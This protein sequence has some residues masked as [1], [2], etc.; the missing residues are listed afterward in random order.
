MMNRDSIRI[1]LIAIVVAVSGF[2]LAFQFVEPSPPKSLTI[3][4]GS[5]T[6]A[7]YAYAK[8]YAS[9]L[10][11]D[12]ITLNVLE[13]GGSV[14]NIGLLSGAKADVAFI[15]GG[16]G[17]AKENPEFQALGSLYFEPLWVFVR[18]GAPIQ[19]LSDLKNRRISAGGEGS[20]TWAVAKQLLGLN[21]IATDDQKVQH[22]SSLDAARGLIS[23]DIEA[24]FFVA[25]PTAP[26]I[27][28]LL[29]ADGLRLLSFA[30]AQAYTSQLRQLSAVTL[31]HGVVSL[32]R[33]VPPADMTLLAPAATLATTD[34]LHPALV[35]LLG[36]ATI[37]VHGAGGLFEAPGQF[38]SAL[39]TDY[40]MNEDARRY[41]SDGPPFLQRF[42]PFWAAILFDRL[43]IL[44]V[45]LVTL[46][47]PLMKVLPPVYRWRVRSRI[48]RWYAD[49]GAIERRAQAGEDNAKL[50]QELDAMMRE[51]GALK[52]PL[53]Y[54]DQAYALRLHIEL[55]QRRLQ[56]S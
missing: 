49:L 23:G 6:G 24:A 19:V 32:S 54:A 18:A 26:L 3:A 27:R 45:P 5:K 38:P 31:H 1:S 50:A 35:Q 9:I 51:V 21:G 12:G 47:I 8:K 46:L 36:R 13:T 43:I 37:E 42:M 40:P 16:V 11:R 55:V 52:V 28:D 30:R 7:Y 17:D 22:L 25:S 53:A 56:S 33:N 10:A 41:I 34:A 20:G 44:A 15:Q 39:Y 14:D 2:A 4:A 48:F 29:A